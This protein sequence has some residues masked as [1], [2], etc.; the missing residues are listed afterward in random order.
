MKQYRR[1]L[2]SLM[3]LAFVG[4]LSFSSCKALRGDP[5]KNCNHPKHGEYMKEQQMKRTGFK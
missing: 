2:A 1:F 5:R 3:I 4:G